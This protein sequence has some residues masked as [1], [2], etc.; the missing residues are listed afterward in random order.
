MSGD[1]H[2]FGVLSRCSVLGTCPGRSARGDAGLR[3]Y[4]SSE[5][6]QG[7][8]RARADETLNQSHRGGGGTAC[9]AGPGTVCGDKTRV[10]VHRAVWR[11]CVESTDE[12]TDEWVYFCFYL[13]FFLSYIT[14]ICFIC[15]IF[16]SNDFKI[17]FC[18]LILICEALCVLKSAIIDLLLLFEDPL[19]MCFKTQIN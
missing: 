8:I 5:K 2:G 18:T 14:G 16:R 9:P 12:L 15:F 11:V 19:L 1:L 3:S 4:R 17:W 10:P 6:L 7:P 13:F